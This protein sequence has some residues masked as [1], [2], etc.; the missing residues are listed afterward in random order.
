MELV[1]LWVEKYKNIEKQ[2]FNF[3]PKFRCEYNPETNELKIKENPNYVSLFPDNINITAIVGKN[4]SGKSSVLEIII[5][6]ANKYDILMD[7]KVLLLVKD[8]NKFYLVSNIKGMKYYPSNLDLEFKD[9]ILSDMIYF[10]YKN[11][12]LLENL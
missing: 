12:K 9:N 10:E 11:N 5:L 4:G 3:S 7:K 8:N 1:Y 6:V 2:G